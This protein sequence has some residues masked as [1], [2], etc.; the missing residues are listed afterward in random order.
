M[1]K[2]TD[3]T[4]INNA[5]KIAQLTQAIGH[6]ST[7][8]G[9]WHPGE[10]VTL[11][12]T[13]L[14]NDVA[15]EGWMATVMFAITK[16]RF[17][18]QQCHL[19]ECLWSICGSFP[20]PRLWNNRVAAIAGNARSTAALGTAAA[21]ATSEAIIYGNR[22]IIASMD[23]IRQSLIQTKQGQ[24]LDEILDHALAAP[25]QG[26]SA[27]GPN[28]DL[29]RL[30]GFGRPITSKDER[31]EPLMKK[32]TELGYEKGEHLQLA[33]DLEAK[34][35][36]RGSK[37]RLNISPIMG[38]LCADQGLT[39][40][41]YNYFI[42]LCCCAGFLACGTDAENHPPGSFYPLPCSAL[43]YLGPAAR[44]WQENVSSNTPETV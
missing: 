6:W 10:G 3:T 43:E 12:H 17:D 26:N 38:A 8:L 44:S 1:S 11:H 34:L 29:A 14:L 40:R 24:S 31:I 25:R 41:Q 4:E 28:R 35:I 27:R 9:G 19:F 23:F 33:F 42:V 20:E 5:E 39:T 37:L 13:D 22:P 18:K 30:P 32:V 36:Q 16:R 2:H 21:V 7:A 15:Q